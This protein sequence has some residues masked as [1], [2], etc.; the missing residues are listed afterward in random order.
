[1]ESSPEGAMQGRAHVVRQQQES[2]GGSS[3]SMATRSTDRSIIGWR[4]EAPDFMAESSAVEESTHATITWASTCLDNEAVMVALAVIS[5][6]A[7]AETF[8]L[9]HRL[10]L[11]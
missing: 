11:G 10:L 9:K 7:A 6:H 2:A 8:I 3:G 5:V 4:I 1:M